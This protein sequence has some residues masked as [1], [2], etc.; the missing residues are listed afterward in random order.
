VAQ[1]NNFNGRAVFNLNLDMISQNESEI[2]FAGSY[3]NPELIPLMEKAAKGTGLTLSFGHDRPEDGPNDWTN[4]S[5][6][7]PFH[8]VGI[9]FGYFGVEDHPHYHRTTDEFETIPQEFYKKSVQTVINAAHILDENLDQV[10]KPA[11][12]SN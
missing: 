3:Y 7:A 2:Y 6:H 8:A 10:A 11:S 4:Q 1:D 9:P 12:K 5:D